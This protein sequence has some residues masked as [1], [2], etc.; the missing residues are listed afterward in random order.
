MT[1]EA[2][3]KRYMDDHGISQA[4]LSR[5]TGISIAKLNL[6]LNDKRALKLDEYCGVCSALGV[7][8]DTFLE[9]KPPGGAGQEPGGSNA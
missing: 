9:P 1:V 5:K 4:F 6:S 8:A 3:I 7:G 2:K